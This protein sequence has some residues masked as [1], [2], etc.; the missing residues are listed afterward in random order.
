MEL[1]RL[2]EETTANV[3]IV[4]GGTASNV[5]PGHCA[6]EGE[7]RSI[8]DDR[9]SATIGAMVDAC[10][11][12]ASEHGVD[13]DV[14][15]REMFRGYRLA[16]SA[17][18]VRLARAALERCGFEP[19]ETATGGGSDANALIAR[20]FECV[21]LANGTEANHT[22]EESVSAERLTEMLAVC[23]AVT[24]LAGDAEAA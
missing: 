11:W 16:S 22:A 2:D 3:G 17:P 8:D 4:G 18:A 19:V 20:G 23:E 12:A 14:D 10:T 21:L 1:G 15:V 7:A 24:E 5:V 13:V 9:A 6:V